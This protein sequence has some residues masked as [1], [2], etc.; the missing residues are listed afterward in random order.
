MGVG[1]VRRDLLDFGN[2][3]LVKEELANV[4]NSSAPVGSVGV[5]GAVEVRKN[6]DVVRTA[7]VMT[8]EEGG[9]LSDS[10]GIGGLQTS[11]ESL[12]DVGGVGALAIA[13]SDNTGVDTGGVTV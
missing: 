3:I 8:R 10:G 12:I 1:G 11:E 13:V 7:C 5:R 2:K 9:K 4:G 6:V